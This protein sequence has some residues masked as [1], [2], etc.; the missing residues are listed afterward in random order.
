[1]VMTLYWALIW[2]VCS[3]CRANDFAA[4]GISEDCTSQEVMTL[5][6]NPALG[7]GFEAAMM[8]A[9][10]VTY[11]STAYNGTRQELITTFDCGSWKPAC[12]VFG[13]YAL[14]WLMHDIIPGQRRA[15]FS[16]QVDDLLLST[17]RHSGHLCLHDAFC[18]PLFSTAG[19]TPYPSKSHLCVTA[20]T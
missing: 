17:G 8:G 19:T 11:N 14:S 12:L 18:Q 20:I 1:M 6:A 13:H 4:T 9:A 2:R 7:P 10:V 3:A 5:D 15:L 16:I